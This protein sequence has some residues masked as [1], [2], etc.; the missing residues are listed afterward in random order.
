MKLKL[1]KNMCMVIEH[2]LGVDVEYDE[3]FDP[4]LMGEHDTKPDFGNNI[5]ERIALCQEVEDFLETKV[6][7]KR[8]WEGNKM[9]ETY[10]SI[11]ITIPTHLLK[12]VAY[13]LEDIQDRSMMLHGD[14]ECWLEIWDNWHLSYEFVDARVEQIISA[15]SN[16]VEQI[17]EEVRRDED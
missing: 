11:T 9:I 5:E 13:V 1:T 15:F 14:G 12:P 7:P 2:A 17:R 3:Y 10:K 4:E 16:R 6:T 8:Y